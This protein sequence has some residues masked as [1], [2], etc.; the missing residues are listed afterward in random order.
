MSEQKTWP[1]G[2]QQPWRLQIICSHE[3]VSFDKQN[4]DPLER[5]SSLLLGS[6]RALILAR[7]IVI[8]TMGF[9]IRLT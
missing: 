2:Q 9:R 3:I 4:K 6:V 7:S 5:S 8:K 1:Q